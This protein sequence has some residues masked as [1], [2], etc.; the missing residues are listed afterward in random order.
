MNRF[1]E[2]C[3]KEVVR[4]D[5]GAVMGRI[6]DAEIENGRIRA[7]IL[8]GRLRLFGLLGREPEKTI[9]WELVKKIGKDVIFV[10]FSGI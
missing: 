8:S 9:P 10:K 4:L 7:V 6:G 1:S 5:D 3:F 2:I